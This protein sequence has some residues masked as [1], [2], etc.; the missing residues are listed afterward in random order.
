MA[1]VTTP[2]WPVPQPHPKTLAAHM[3]Q[4]G[5]DNFLLGDQVRLRYGL[6]HHNGQGGVGGKNKETPRDFYASEDV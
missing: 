1:R 4:C 5:Q 6:R 2:S 3:A